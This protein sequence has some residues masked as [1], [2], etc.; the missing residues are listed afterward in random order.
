MIKDLS[1]VVFGI[2]L[3][4]ALVVGCVIVAALLLPFLGNFL[5]AVVD[6][7]NRVYEF[8]TNLAGRSEQ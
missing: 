6:L 5:D 7:T 8:S 2:L 1:S 3:M 4:I